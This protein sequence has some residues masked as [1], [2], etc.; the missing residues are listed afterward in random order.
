MPLI[1]LREIYDLEDIAAAAAVGLYEFLIE[2]TIDAQ[3]CQTLR[4][5]IRDATAARE[6]GLLA[7]T[8]GTEPPILEP[9][10]DAEI[11]E[12]SFRRAPTS[13]VERCS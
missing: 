12:V 9:V 8:L 2:P 7:A 4:T 3:I 13:L 5:A 1:T 6:V 10:S 11:C